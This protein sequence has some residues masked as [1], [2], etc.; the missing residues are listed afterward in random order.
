MLVPNGPPNENESRRSI[1]PPLS[2]L[3]IISSFPPVLLSSWLLSSCHLVIFG[4][5]VLLQRV[6]SIVSYRRVLLLSAVCLGRVVSCL[7]T[8]AATTAAADDD[9]DDF[10][11]S[12]TDEAGPAAA[13]GG[14]GAGGAND[15]VNAEDLD[16]MLG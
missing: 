7:Y 15:N 13:A 11:N 8:L 3:V 12:L 10:L 2:Q 5:P 9:L 16:K 6:Y 14:G 1:R 4:R